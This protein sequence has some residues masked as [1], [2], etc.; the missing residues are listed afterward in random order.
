MSESIVYDDEIITSH[1]RLSL[2]IEELRNENSINR[3]KIED[4]HE[5]LRY[6]EE[7][8]NDLSRENEL[9]SA[10]LENLVNSSKTCEQAVR[11]FQEDNEI[12]KEKIEML[13]E[14]KSRRE[15]EM[16]LAFQTLQVKLKSVE[17]EHLEQIDVY[18]RE[19]KQ[20]K[21]TNE[22]LRGSLDKLGKDFEEEKRSCK[23][24]LEAI[25]EKQPDLEFADK[26]INRYS[27]FECANKLKE[28]NMKRLAADEASESG[29]FDDNNNRRAD[30]L[31]CNDKNFYLERFGVE[32]FTRE[33]VDLSCSKPRGQYVREIIKILG[34]V[35]EEYEQLNSKHDQH[36]SMYISGSVRSLFEVLLVVMFGLNPVKNQFCLSQLLKVLANE[37]LPQKSKKPAISLS[38]R[39]RFYRSYFRSSISKAVK[40]KQA[41]HC[42]VK[43]GHSPDSNNSRTLRIKPE[44]GKLVEFFRFFKMSISHQK[45]LFVLIVCFFF[46][47]ACFRGVL[48]AS[49]SF[50]QMMSFAE[51]SIGVKN[52]FE[53]Q[54]AN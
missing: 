38:K 2:E 11:H 6:A 52:P 3:Q 32:I 37:R 50:S 15:S 7:V 24:Q 48:Q 44:S 31:S 22:E 14:E 54:R 16:N 29:C 39:F 42:V 27:D 19:V 20:L 51:N 8:N 49:S 47:F 12:L 46:V 18:K 5:Q 35:R 33:A 45:P 4:M 36:N 30:T 34:H 17:T 28:I 25:L 40:F 43:S 23:L 10:R 26:S 53:T 41:R 1:S 9:Q 21:M 13:R